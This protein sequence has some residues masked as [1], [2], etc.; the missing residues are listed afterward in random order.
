M[1]QSMPAPARTLLPHFS[2]CDVS[3]IPQ[4]AMQLISVDHLSDLGLAPPAFF[5][6]TAAL[7]GSGWW[8]LLSRSVITLHHWL[9]SHSFASGTSHTI[10]SSLHTVTAFD[11]TTMWSFAHWHKRFGHLC[12]SRLVS[13]YDLQTWW[14]GATPLPFQA[15]CFYFPLFI[16]FTQM[17]GVW[18]LSFQI[19]PLLC[20]LHQIF[21]PTVRLLRTNTINFIV[22]AV[23]VAKGRK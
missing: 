11:T 18:P 16:F 1:V 14:A 20:D 2:T 8:S 12:G 3:R 9:T 23:F 21:V 4:L 7:V 19:G 13:G 10:A 17:S 6:Q 15:L 5:C 22:L